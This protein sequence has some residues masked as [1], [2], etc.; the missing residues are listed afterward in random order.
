MSKSEQH[1]RDAFAG[2]SQA[3]RKYLAFAEKADKEGYPQVAQPITHQWQGHPN[4]G[5]KACDHKEIDGRREHNVNDQACCKQLH[6]WCLHAKN[7]YD[8]AHKQ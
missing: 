8:H 3:N 5:Q 7:Q 1:L 4:N 2:E 6:D